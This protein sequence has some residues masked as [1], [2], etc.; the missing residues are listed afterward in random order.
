MSPRNN[1]WKLGAAAAAMFHMSAHYAAAAEIDWKMHVIFPEPRAESMAAQSWADGVKER[2]DGR[3]QV[4]V[5]PGGAL[6]LKDVDMLRILPPGNAVQAV[7]LFAGYLSRDAPELA[8]AAPNEAL[9]TWEEYVQIVPTLEAIYAEAYES[10]GIKHLSSVLIPPRQINVFCKTPVST[11]EE[12]RGHK[13]RVWTKSLADIF[14]KLGIA[15]VVIPQSEMYLALQTGVVDCAVYTLDAVNTIS[16]HEVAPYGAAIAAYGGSI[17]IVASKAAWDKL[18]ED[19]Q[20]ILQE[21]ADATHKK[22]VEDYAAGTVEKV[23]ADKFIAAGG[24]L[25]DFPQ[26]DKDAYLKAAREVWIDM[27]TQLGEST[28][29]NARRIASELGWQ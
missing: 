2:T 17:N 23:E 12:L 28:A 14:D 24:K 15:G 29:E 26:A 25:T 18:P 16:L 7:L 8:Y 13:V 27:T 9:G 22:T 21:E 5:Y 1:I 3:M 4:S 10:Y 19:I 6:G 20:T 11:L